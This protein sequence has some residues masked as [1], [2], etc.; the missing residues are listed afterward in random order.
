M[1]VLLLFLLSLTA[2][3]TVSG[4]TNECYE[5]L[6]QKGKIQ[7]NAGNYDKAIVKWT[8]ALECPD[9]TADDRDTLNSWITKAQH[10][11]TPSVSTPITRQSYEP[12]T[13]FV[14]DN[15]FKYE[16]EMVFVQGGTFKMGSKKSDDLLDGKPV[17]TVTVSSYYIGKYE[18]TQ[19]QWSAVMGTNPSYFNKCDD[20]PVELVNYDDVNDYLAKLSA[21]T[22]KKY[23]LPTEAE[24]EFAARGGNA[25][26]GYKY[27]GSNTIHDVAW[28]S[29]NANNKTH[30]IGTK[31]ANE[32]GLFD[33]SGNVEEL[34]SDRYD[35]Y[36]QSEAVT[37]P[38]GATSGTDRVLRGGS[39]DSSDRWHVTSRKSIHPAG[40][41]DY[42]GFRVVRYD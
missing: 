37:N 42:M 35:L 38:L 12:Q 33:V 36:Y 30:I 25:S 32:L 22:G 5:S 40:R 17:H 7:F 14:Q 34:C 9:L 24:W 31:S 4:Q 15:T 41:H 29:S 16:P 20:C 3:T 8:G 10:P 21:K 23:R 26:K 1:R 27:S 19:K 13:V 2:A 28:Y 11:P 18:V 6:F 39:W